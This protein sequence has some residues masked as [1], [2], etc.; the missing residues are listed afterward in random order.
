MKLSHDEGIANH[1]DPESCAFVRKNRGKTLIPRSEGRAGYGAVKTIE[2]R[3]PTLY[4]ERKVTR[5][6]SIGRESL[7]PSA[8]RDPEHIRKYLAWNRRGMHSAHERVREGNCY[9]IAL[10]V[11][12]KAGVPP[13]RDNAACTDLCGGRRATIVPTATHMSPH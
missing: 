13:W 6:E 11:F 7:W 3:V 12:P 5:C 2:F 10:P 9:S 1:I 4:N 8:F